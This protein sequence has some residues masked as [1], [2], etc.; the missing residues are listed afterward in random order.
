MPL[1]GGLEAYLRMHVLRP[2]LPVLFASGFFR[3]PSIEALVE[4]CPGPAAVLMKPFGADD[5]I[6]S[7]ST[8]LSPGSGDDGEFE[9]ADSN[10]EEN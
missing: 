10:Q 8:A 7:V 3:G 6:K 2:D 1:M 5:L 4:G 9:P